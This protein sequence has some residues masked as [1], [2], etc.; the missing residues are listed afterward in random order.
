MTAKMDDQGVLVNMDSTCTTL[1]EQIRRLVS[2]RL[3][4]T[5]ALCKKSLNK[6]RRKWRE[7]H[8]SSE[9]KSKGKS[10]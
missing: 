5:H 4:G 2:L 7:R 6:R 1:Q 10:N 8:R 9:V 3:P